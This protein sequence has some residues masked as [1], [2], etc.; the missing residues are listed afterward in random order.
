MI[1]RARVAAVEAP[2]THHSVGRKGASLYC[3]DVQD[4][5]AEVGLT[6]HGIQLVVFDYEVA[7]RVKV[8]AELVFEVLGLPELPDAEPP[9]ENDEPP[10]EA[11][12]GEARLLE[13]LALRGFSETNPA[14]RDD[15]VKAATEIGLKLTKRY[16]AELPD[17]PAEGGAPG[18]VG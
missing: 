3:V 8:G 18:P 10:E 16:I 6:K 9:P 5:T 11:F 2:I 15:V 17:K 14:Y 4:R 1:F 13:E 12:K 7:K